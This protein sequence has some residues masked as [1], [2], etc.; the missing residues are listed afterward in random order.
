MH[1][2]SLRKYDKKVGSFPVEQTKEG[3][4]R[5][6]STTTSIASDKSGDVSNWRA[7]VYTPKGERRLAQV[8][9]KSRSS[10]RPVHNGARLDSERRHRCEII[11]ATRNAEFWRPGKYRVILTVIAGGLARRNWNNPYFAGCAQSTGENVR[12]GRIPRG[13]ALQRSISLVSPSSYSSLSLLYVEEPTFNVLK[14]I[15]GQ[16]TILVYTLLCT[17]S[18]EDFKMNC[19]IMK[20]SRFHFIRNFCL[21]I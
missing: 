8:V 12:G 15:Y 9:A 14:H 3:Q 2:D 5:S 18:E 17:S 10:L 13:Y 21:N 16:R 20:K 1:L 11:E 6:G 4:K 7:P 19:S